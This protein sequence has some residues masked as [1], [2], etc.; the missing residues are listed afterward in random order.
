M[1]TFRR[2]LSARMASCDAAS[3]GGEA[4]WEGGMR[5][6]GAGWG[7]EGKGQA[8]GRAGGRRRRSRR[9]SLCPRSAAI[10]P[11]RNGP[12]D[13]APSGRPSAPLETHR[14]AAQ[15]RSSP[16][17]ARRRRLP[18]RRSGAPQR[19]GRRESDMGPRWAPRSPK[20]CSTASLGDRW[21]F[22]LSCAALRSPG[23]P[24][25]PPAPR[26]RA[27]RRP[28]FA[29]P[30]LA[31]RALGARARS[32]D[33][34]VVRRHRGGPFGAAPFPE[35]SWIEIGGAWT[36]P[37]PLPLAEWRARR[38]ARSAACGSSAA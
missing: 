1:T 31:R 32:R 28:R 3:A 23:P 15:S 36:D 10:R 19:R 29:M 13:Q 25:A 18:W 16:T 21:P 5:V 30:T 38:P 33:P 37:R 35:R 17:R 22:P 34:L 2:K 8:V 26:A 11:A 14:S 27:R 12:N 20:Y 4:R 6:G 9:A 24:P 7:W